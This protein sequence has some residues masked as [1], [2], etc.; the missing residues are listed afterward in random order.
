MNHPDWELLTAFE[1][2]FAEQ[3]LVVAG[4]DEVGRGP[5]AGPVVAAA[6]ILDLSEPI[7]GLDDSKR[8]SPTKREALYE[9]IQERALAIGIGAAGPRTIEHVNIYE[10]SRLAMRRAIRRLALRPDVVL[11]DAMPLPGAP[12][13]TVPII[14]GD[15]RSAS[16][17][18][19][20]IVAKVVRD[21]YMDALH[22]HFPQ[23]GFNRHKGYATRVHREALR[24]WGPTAAHRHTFLHD[25]AGA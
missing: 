25:P 6:V 4:T 8:L 3:G 2:V 24:E 14:R 10:A 20:S 7:V 23:Y 1:T 15:S 11:S 22:E 9:V 21:R 13:H 16:I 19:A 17:A 18:A 12:H 5:L